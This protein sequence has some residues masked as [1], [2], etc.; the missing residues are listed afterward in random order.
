VKALTLTQPW[1][2]LVAIGAK[3]YET[4]SWG[5]TY[6]GPLAIHAAASF[7]VWAREFGEVLADEHPR[8]WRPGA[9]PRGAVV[10]TCRLVEVVRCTIDSPVLPRGEQLLGDFAP[11]RFAWRLEEVVLVDPAVPAKGALGLWEWNR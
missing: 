4:R 5:T 7:P 11:G 3:S 2:S 8:L 10:A 6:R 9:L 1:A